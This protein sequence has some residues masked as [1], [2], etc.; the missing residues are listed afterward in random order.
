MMR[1]SVSY[2][3]FV[4]FI[5][6]TIPL[7]AQ[8]KIPRMKK[9]Q[10]SAA[11]KLKNKKYTWATPYQEFEKLAQFY[12]QTSSRSTI[13]LTKKKNLTFFFIGNRH[14][15]TKNIWRKKN[16]GID[17]FSTNDFYTLF[18]FLPKFASF[19]NCLDC[20]IYWVFGN[21]LKNFFSCYTETRVGTTLVVAARTSV[22]L[23]Q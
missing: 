18:I 4:Y 2:D 16:N 14:E 19:Y 9:L 12:S 3:F 20:M 23:H 8:L 22:H 17:L 7:P 6:I 10:Q 11:H 21:E 13:L 1:P 15:L 5:A